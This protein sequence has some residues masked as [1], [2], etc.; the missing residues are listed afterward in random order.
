M[1]CGKGSKKDPQS[2]C[3]CV[4]PLDW[5]ENSWT[6][7]LHS[8]LRTFPG[9]S[10]SAAQPG[11]KNLSPTPDPKMWHS[12]GALRH[13][14]SWAMLFPGCTAIKELNN[15][16]THLECPWDLFGWFWLEELLSCPSGVVT[17]LC[18][19]T[20]NCMSDAPRANRIVPWQ[21][22]LLFRVWN[23]CYFGF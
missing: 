15:T 3:S 13:C 18:L 7:S 11:N 10:R 23:S 2:C 20:S 9:N 1:I 5:R 21:C 14:F 6:A 8:G 4:L 17:A 22:L 19:R 12:P 16:K